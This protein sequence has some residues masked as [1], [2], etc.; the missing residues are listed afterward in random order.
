MGFVVLG[1]QSPFFCGPKTTF[2][3]L[4]RIAK[5][6]KECFYG[7]NDVG[8]G[9]DGIYVFDDVVGRCHGVFSAKTAFGP[10]PAGVLRLCGRGDDCR[11]HLVAAV[12]GHGAG[13]GDGDGG[14]ATGGRRGDLWFIFP[15]GAGCGAAFH[16]PEDG[17]GTSRPG[18]FT[19]YAVLFGGDAA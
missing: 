11:F 2:C 9:R 19:Q 17:E 12:T 4:H 10:G 5:N 14:L 6:G 13:R 7:C 3:F 1:L 16:L 8:G 15:V 18:F